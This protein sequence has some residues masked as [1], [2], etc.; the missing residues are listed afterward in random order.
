MAGTFLDAG[1]G[2]LL[3][4]LSATW[5]T[6]AFRVGS[7]D[8][9]SAELAAR[10]LVY[11]MGKGPLR[12]VVWVE[13][14]LEGVVAA[15]AVAAW[16]V[17][18]GVEPND[19]F[20]GN[21][22][23]ATWRRTW[24]REVYARGCAGVEGRDIQ[25]EFEARC[26]PRL[27]ESATWHDLRVAHADA[28]RR[29]LANGAGAVWA[30]V[31]DRVARALETPVRELEPLVRDFADQTQLCWFGPQEPHMLAAV[32]LF[33]RTGCELGWLGIL[34]TLATHCGMGWLMRDVSVLSAF[35]T[36]IER[37]EVDGRPG[38]FVSVA[39]ADGWSVRL[40]GAGPR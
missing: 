18:R 23:Y 40:S 1:E 19:R 24:G 22:A 7:P 16:L 13:S 29:E 35:P 4:R 5:L 25:A 15:T 21:E 38:P 33:Q 37:S 32:D 8:L 31:G 10:A 17:R 27:G 2:A 20:L 3:E 36:A 6:R 11:A 26:G 39:Y 9:G 30:R 12:R 34:V 14:P 28:I